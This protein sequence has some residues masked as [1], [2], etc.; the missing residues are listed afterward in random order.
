MPGEDLKLDNDSTLTCPFQVIIHQYSL[1]PGSGSGAFPVP[2][3]SFSTHFHLVPRLKMGNALFPFHLH[4][5]MVWTG[6]C[7]LIFTLLFTIPFIPPD[8]RMRNVLSY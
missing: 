2:Y 3:L 8:P 6:T 1:E 4:T 5:F 7:F